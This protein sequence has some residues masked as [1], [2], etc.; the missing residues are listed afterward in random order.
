MGPTL[1]FRI[2]RCL[3]YTGEIYLKTGQRFSLDATGSSTFYLSILVYIVICSNEL[4]VWS[5][6]LMPLSTIFQLYRG[7]HRKLV[8]FTTYAISA[9]LH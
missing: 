5:C 2:D 7:S 6:C 1:V 4:W 9:Y 8:G 3:V